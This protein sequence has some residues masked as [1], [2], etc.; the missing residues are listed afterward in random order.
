[1]E[2]KSTF[3]RKRNDKYNVYIEYIDENGKAKQ[4]SQGYYKTKS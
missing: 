2:I 1:M 4:K 3:I